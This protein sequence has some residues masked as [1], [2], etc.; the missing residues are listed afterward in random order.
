MRHFFL[1]IAYQNQ[2]I[3][4]DFKRPKSISK[5]NPPLFNSKF[6]SLINSVVWLTSSTADCWSFAWRCKCQSFD[7]NL[8]ESIRDRKL[9]DQ[10]ENSR[11]VL[12]I[13]DPGKNNEQIKNSSE[14]STSLLKQRRYEDVFLTLWRS[15]IQRTRR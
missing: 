9:A 2:S 7:E 15:S 4:L 13:K 5:L 10:S 1:P 11:F 14:K 6:N 3:A 8:I 12:V